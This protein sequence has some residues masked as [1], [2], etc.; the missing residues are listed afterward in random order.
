MAAAGGNYYLSK[1]GDEAIH[2]RGRVHDH[3]HEFVLVDRSAG[4]ITLI[5]AAVDWG[6]YRGIRCDGWH[7][8]PSR[9]RIAAGLSVPRKTQAL[10]S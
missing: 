9:N 10:L 2:D 6:N 5:V 4:R 8:W 3:Y 7:R 1:L